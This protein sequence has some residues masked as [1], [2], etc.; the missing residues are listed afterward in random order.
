MQQ[1]TC[2]E[3]S[4]RKL[5]HRIKRGGAT[6]HKHLQQILTFLQKKKKKK[7][8]DKIIQQN[9]IPRNKQKQLLE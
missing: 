4:N 8:N 6:Q 2:K 5:N 3:I 9:F 7:K 1:L